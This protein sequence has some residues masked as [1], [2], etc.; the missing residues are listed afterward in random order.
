MR[1]RTWRG[2]SKWPRG[3]YSYIE[4]LHSDIGIVPSD[5]G[6]FSGV[7]EVTGI[8][9]GKIW[10]LW[11]I[12][13]RLTSPQGAGAPPIREEAELDLGRGRHPLSISYSLSFPFSPSGR[14]KKGWGR[15]LLGP[16]S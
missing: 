7:P 10:A 8:L 11:A 6:I 3:K 4:R 15:I 5:S 13:G 9:G 14:R 1:S 16:E 12:G 2:V